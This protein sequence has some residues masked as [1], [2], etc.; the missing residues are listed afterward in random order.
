MQRACSVARLDTHSSEKCCCR[1][2]HN[3]GKASSWVPVKPGMS[4]QRP[5]WQKLR[6]EQDALNRSSK[7]AGTCTKMSA[8]QA[9]A[10]LGGICSSLAGRTAGCK[11]DNIV[12]AVWASDCRRN[13]I[14]CP[15]SIQVCN[16]MTAGDRCMLT[17]HGMTLPLTGKDQPMM[18][19]V[20]SRTPPSSQQD[21][22]TSCWRLILTDT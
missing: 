9:R 19:Q 8:Q 18:A 22:S 17:M 12:C 20:L 11:A 5:L 16:S 6:H 1:G 10:H 7:N 13:T 21:A 14:C 2:Q 3:P 15:A 4:R